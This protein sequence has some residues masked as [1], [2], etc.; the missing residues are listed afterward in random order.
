MTEAK[1]AR[2]V[3]AKAMLDNDPVFFEMLTGDERC[4]T[5]DAM[6]TALSQAGMV[7][8]PR[9]PTDVM[10]VRGDDALIEE[11]NSHRFALNGG[12]T[13]AQKTW[14]AMISAVQPGHGEE[15]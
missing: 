8:V 9:E 15:R 7:V 4:D 13:P 6:L 10:I 11:L 3:I 14:A 5:A 2:D 1:S 12:D